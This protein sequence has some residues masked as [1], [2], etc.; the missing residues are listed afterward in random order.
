MEYLLLV[1]VETP[2]NPADPEELHRQ[3]LAWVDEM[4]RTGVRLL[5][6]RLRSATEAR[7]VRIRENEVVVSD[8]P[9]AESKEKLGGFDVIKC[10]DFDAAVEVASRHPMAKHGVIEIREL[11]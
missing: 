2:F 8:G 10:A 6:S 1:C 5:G 7:T 4:D 11:W 9:F 3:T